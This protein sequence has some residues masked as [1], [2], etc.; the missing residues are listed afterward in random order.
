M[1]HSSFLLNPAWDVK[2]PSKNYQPVL[3]TIQMVFKSSV[4]TCFEA[5]LVMA[6]ELSEQQNV[7]S[8]PSGWLALWL[9]GLSICAAPGVHVCTDQEY[10]ELNMHTQGPILKPSN[11]F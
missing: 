5:I 6:L 8:M 4:W 1:G 3:K 11:P 2:E 10:A 9:F 7:V